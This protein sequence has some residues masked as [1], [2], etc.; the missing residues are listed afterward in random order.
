MLSRI[1]RIA[2]LVGHARARHLLVACGLLIGLVL[3]V[4]IVLISLEL[5]NDARKHNKQDLRNLALVLSEEIDRNFQAVELVQLGLIEHMRELGIDTPEKFAQQMTSFAAHQNLADRVV[6]EP[7]I[8]ALVLLDRH[9]KVL[10]F[11]RTWP[12]PV[13]DLADRDFFKVLIANAA[14]ASF[15]SGPVQSRLGGTSVILVSRKFTAPDGQLIGIVSSGLRTTYFEGAFARIAVD[16]DGAINLMRQDGVVLARYPPVPAGSGLGAAEAE[17]TRAAVDGGVIL[18]RSL[19]DNKERLI[20]P[21]TVAHFPLMIAVSTTVDA[22]LGAW[23]GEAR[24]LAVITFLLELFIAGIVALAVR[25]LRSYERLE[26]AAT[27]QATAEAAQARAES[28]LIVAQEREHA[29]RTLQIQ[30]QRFDLALSNML[31]GL[32]MFDGAG[33]LLMVNRRFCTMFGLA[34]D[35]LAAGISYHEVTDRI[36]TLGNITADDMAAFRRR[37]AKLVS[38]HE[39]TIDTWEMSDGRAYT[40]THQPMEAGWISSYEDITERR[41]IEARM[42]YLADHDALTD[43][44]NR[45]RFREQLEHAMIHARRGQPLAL[46]FLDLDQFKSVN[47]T[48]GHPIGDALLQAVAARLLQGMRETDSVARLGGDEFAIIQ[49]PIEQPTEATIFAARLIERLDA[50]FDIAGHQ[51]SIGTSIGI[52]FAPEDG[53]DPD[54]LLKCAD[55]ALYRAKQD[56]RGVYRLFQAGMDAQMQ[57]RRLLELDLRHALTAGQLEPFYQPCVNVRTGVVSGFEAL[58]R[59]RHPERGIVPPGQ[60]IPLAEEIGLIVPIGAWVLRQACFAAASWPGNMRVSVNLSPA[61]FKSADLIATVVEALHDADLSADRLELEITETV[62]L[63]DTDATMA[64][65]RQLQALGLR[66][67]LD[68]FGTGYSSLSYLQRFPFDRIKIDQSFVRDVCSKRHCAAIVRAV[69][70]LSNELGIATTAEG[71]ETREQFDVVTQAGCTEVQGYLYSPAV[72]I[73]AVPEL[74]QMIAAMPRVAVACDVPE[75][76]G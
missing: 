44:P 8:E 46:L 11:S 70:S 14:V 16:G 19:F 40:V 55:L 57:A 59:W 30:G 65:L 24:V 56:G 27:A 75:Y 7:Q 47:D 53:V 20:A 72:P 62:I 42:A 34:T 69:A 6:G 36:V 63:Q 68:D 73:D 9:G 43:L 52:A 2:A 1:A 26:T 58:L 66:I 76:V 54:Q 33:C 31:Q 45:V 13:V 37:R 51:I 22:S 29:A 39:R 23:F 71:V 35:A 18:R 5:R 67:A 4:A 61:Q 38:Q 15:I 50:P 49:A 48:L 10:N 74:L 41:V 32:M 12:V 3:A 64:I 21:R 60:F 28:A 17:F 25:H